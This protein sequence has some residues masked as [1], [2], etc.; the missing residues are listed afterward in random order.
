[1]KKSLISAAAVVI[2]VIILAVLFGGKSST[3]APRVRSGGALVTSWKAE[4][5]TVEKKNQMVYPT[6][7]F[8]NPQTGET[9]DQTFQGDNIDATTLAKLAKNRI[10]SLEARDAAFGTLLPGVITLPDE[11]DL[12]VP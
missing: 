9:F 12:I 10:R 11:D 6:V 2:A 1:M 3:P 5:I 8:T 4:L 7:R